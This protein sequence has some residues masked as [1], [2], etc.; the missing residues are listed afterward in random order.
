MGK[1][2]LWYDIAF[3]VNGPLN[4]DA[5][6]GHRCSFDERKS[7]EGDGEYP[8]VGDFGRVSSSH[9]FCI[10]VTECRLVIASCNHVV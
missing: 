6:W 5:H 2:F 10:L 3:S 9:D 8:T 1:S 7:G 4:S